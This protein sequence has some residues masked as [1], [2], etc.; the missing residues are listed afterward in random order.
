M[1]I[2]YWMDH[3]N[4]MKQFCFKLWIYLSCFHWIKFYEIIFD[5]FPKNQPDRSLIF[6]I[7]FKRLI[8][9]VFY[10]SNV[11]LFGFGTVR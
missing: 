9:Y 2:L 11:N 4:G 3:F 10:D 6:G 8:I 7:K 1:I 5:T